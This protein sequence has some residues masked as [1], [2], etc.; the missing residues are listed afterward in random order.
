MKHVNDLAYTV[1]LRSKNV[2]EAEVNEASAGFDA[3]KDQRLGNGLL[4][5]EVRDSIEYRTV[6]QR[7]NIAFGKLQ[8]FNI[9][10]PKEFLRRASIER[11]TDKV[12]NTGQ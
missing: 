8:K 10:S 1:W 3:F 4:P 7:Y 12:N 11:R 6:K 2:L 9:Q 5:N